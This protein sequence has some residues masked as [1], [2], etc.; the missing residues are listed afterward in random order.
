MTKQFRIGYSQ[1][2]SSWVYFTADNETKARQLVTQVENG[3]LETTELPNS[4]NKVVFE[5]YALVDALE[6]VEQN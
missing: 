2:I 3:D 5:S 1:E 6:E 4:Y